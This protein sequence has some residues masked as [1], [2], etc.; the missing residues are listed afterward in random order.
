MARL[1]EHQGKAI[2][3]ANGFSIPRGRAVTTSEQAAVA[4]N[5]LLTDGG[6]VVIKIQAWMTGRAAIGGVAFARTPEQASAHAARM[7]AMKVGQFPVEAVLVEEKISIAREFFLSLAIDDAAR[8]PVIIF[9]DGGG[10]GIE[11]RATSTRK[12]TC[13]VIKGPDDAAVRSAASSCGLSTAQS[14]GLCESIH[15]LFAAARSVEARSLEINPLVLTTDG[16]FVAAD[17][18]QIAESPSMI[19]PSCGIQ[20]SASKSPA[21]LIIPQPRSNASRMPQNKVITAEHFISPSWQ[22]L[23]AKTRTVS[24]DSTAPA[25]VDR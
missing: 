15:K 12:I 10:S 17:C 8:A 5:E 22:Q 18:Q 9:A 3:A 1:H 7:L 20:N 23:Q 14:Q 13:D 24:S 2:L 16:K 11:E 4:A 19:T 25:A 6:E 21:N